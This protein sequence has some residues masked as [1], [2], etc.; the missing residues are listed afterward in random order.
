M[1]DENETTQ[2]TNDDLQLSA[3][4]RAMLAEARERGIPPGE[5]INRASRDYHREQEEKA[6]SAPANNNTHDT[7]PTLR[8]V[9]ERVEQKI[10]ER[11]Q[12]K[13]K[14]KAK[15]E[16]ISTI[17]KVIDEE[18]SFGDDPADRRQI[19]S[20]ALLHVH[21]RAM[22]DGLRGPAFIQALKEETQ[23][24]IERRLAKMGGSPKTKKADL[25]NRLDAARNAGDGGGGRSGGQGSATTSLR[26]LDHM[27]D[28]Q[29]GL[30]TNWPSDADLDRAA[31]QDAEAFLR[32]ARNKR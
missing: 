30:G 17:G 1:S 6:R 27:G 25:D 32:K 3:D 16:M 15:E 4:E 26:S 5:M 23:K 28:E 24:E 8:E 18:G 29:F 13:A 10:S 11:D 19:Q 7:I 20:E 12:L 14:E 2:E 22:K 9:D 31:K 21:E